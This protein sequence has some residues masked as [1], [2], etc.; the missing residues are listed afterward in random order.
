[1]EINRAYAIYSKAFDHIMEVE[2]GYVN[3]RYDRGGET[4]FGIS[5]RQYPD[6]DIYNL[7]RADA[8]RI[9]E[10]DYWNKMRLSLLESE[11]IMIEMFD[12]GVNAGTD[13]A[14]R[15]IQRSL[16]LIDYPV[17]IDGR[18]GNETISAINYASD[19]YEKAL[20]NAFKGYEW[21]HYKNIVLKNP[22]QRRFIRG[23]LARI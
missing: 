12:F 23:W 22:S 20:L 4:K 5:K 14:A 9:Y 16:I 7:T 2:G 21:L 13:R 1:M 18:I 8:K 11:K 17:K 3:D 6:V 19:N 15:S 10:R